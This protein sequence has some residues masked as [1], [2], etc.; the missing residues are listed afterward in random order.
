M[1]N[2]KY[3]AFAF[4]KEEM[5]DIYRL[6]ETMFTVANL[7]GELDFRTMSNDTYYLWVGAWKETYAA[8]SATSRNIKRLQ[9]SDPTA[10]MG[11]H[12]L[13]RLSNT[14]L[15]ARQAG[16]DIRRSAGLPH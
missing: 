13:R 14:M 4:T 2:S 12:T 5:T 3:R 16:H 8:L 7:I 10:I 6:R 9:R 11:V 1:T 15:N